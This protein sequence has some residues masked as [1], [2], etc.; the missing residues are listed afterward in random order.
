VSTPEPA[1]SELMMLEPSD[2]LDVVVVLLVVVLVVV[3]IGL[4]LR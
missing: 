3:I 1:L 4:R 2:A